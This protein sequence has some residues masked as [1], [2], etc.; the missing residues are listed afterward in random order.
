MHPRKRF[1]NVRGFSLL[2]TVLA[3]SLS[4]V[5]MASL[6]MVFKVTKQSWNS[7][8][9]KSELLQHV[10]LALARMSL[11]MRYATNLVTATTGTILFDTTVLVDNDETTTEQI[12]YFIS[13][14]ALMRSIGAAG[15]PYDVA[16][17]NTSGGVVFSFPVVQPVKLDALGNVIPLDV[18]DPLSMAI[19]LDIQMRVQRDTDTMDVR[20][21]VNFRGK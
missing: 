10:R 18:A 16:G 12:S 5:I 3:I 4:A 6:T 21:L 15:T 19:G 17:E 13:G 2:E 14:N 20:T 9:R 7:N 11:D 8:T 1:G